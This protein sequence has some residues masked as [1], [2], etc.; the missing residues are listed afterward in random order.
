MLKKFLVIFMILLICGGGGY[1]AYQHFYKRALSSV[2]PIPSAVAQ[3]GAF[4]VTISA[5]GL[6]DAAVKK[7]VTSDFGG[8]I[9]KL[10]P[11]GTY[12]KENEPV[13]WLDVSELEDQKKEYEVE[14]QLAETRLKQKEETLRLTKLKN[15]LSL[16]AENAKVDFQDLKLQDAKNNYDKQKILVDKNLVAR[17]ALDDAQIALL[18]AELSLKQ[19]KINLKKLEEDQAS[20]VKIKTSDVESA[21]VDLERQK[22]KLND[23][24]DKIEKAVIK[25]NGQ[26]HISYAIIWKSGKMSKIAE[27]DQPWRRATLM[28]IPDPATMQAKI[29]IS[30]IDIGRINIGQPAEITVDALPGQTFKG[31]VETKSV[32]PI[33]DP[34][35]FFGGGGGSYARGKEF[36]VRIKLDNPDDNFRQGM[37]ARVRVFINKL[38]DVT[39]IPQEAL[40]GE[41]E[42]RY[43]FIKK[44]DS[45]EKRTVAFG[46][47]NQNHIIITSGVSADETVLLRD[48]TKKIERIGTLDELKKGAEPAIGTASQ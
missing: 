7:N 42:N 19:A 11:E 9:I 21:K 27:G 17:S 37:T 5:I 31:K 29:P 41:K 26:G 14:V 13:I 16:K 34:E 47:S 28:E 10:I 48:P 40:F 8:K 1:Y 32:V 20:D 6:L 12:V 25:A 33:G 30:E 4:D 15:E 22:Q 44:G 43:V 38:N 36:D 3:K 2:A 23:A 24:L 39:F 35:E 18:Q 46:D 45:Y